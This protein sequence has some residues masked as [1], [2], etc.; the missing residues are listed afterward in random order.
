MP[1]P[2]ESLDMVL[3]KKE[4]SGRHH[5]EEGGSQ[6]D[7]E[8]LI[9]KTADKPKQTTAGREKPPPLDNTLPS[10]CGDIRAIEKEMFLHDVMPYIPPTPTHLNGVGILGGLLGHRYVSNLGLRTCR[11]VFSP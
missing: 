5:K 8:Y 9:N 7:P 3:W 1:P 4:S 6:M 11:F 10:S 2:K